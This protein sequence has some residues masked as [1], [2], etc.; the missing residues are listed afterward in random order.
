MSSNPVRTHVKQ[1]RPDSFILY[2]LETIYNDPD[3]MTRAKT[4]PCPNQP[5]LMENN[6][7]SPLVRINPGRGTKSKIS[8]PTLINPDGGQKAESHHFV[9][10][11]PDRGAK[12]K[13]HTMSGSTWIGEQDFTPSPGQPGQRSKSRILRLIPD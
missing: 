2:Y 8:H 7:N 6:K 9:Q 3:Q 13:F 4:S 10:I 1:S 12:A 5:R 11:G